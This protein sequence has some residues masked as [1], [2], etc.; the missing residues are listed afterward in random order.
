MPAWQEPPVPKF[1]EA[2]GAVA[3]GRVAVSG[4]S[5]RVSSSSGNKAYD[6]RYDAD[7]QAIMANDNASYW[8]GYLG[9]PSIAYLLATGVLPYDARLAKLMAGI[10]W[11]DLNTRYKN[12]FEAAVE[13]VLGTLDEQDADELRAYVADLAAKT[14]AL[15]LALLGPRSRPPSGY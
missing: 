13:E 8:K 1:Y 10:R 12:D 9:Y 4:D 7:A 11:K 3:D 5:A 6:V 15:R 14:A 2:L